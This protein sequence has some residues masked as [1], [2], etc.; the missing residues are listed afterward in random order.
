M[1]LRQRLRENYTLQPD[2]EAT[3]TFVCQ[4]DITRVLST[5]N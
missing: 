4:R 1:D 5:R 3:R 2:L